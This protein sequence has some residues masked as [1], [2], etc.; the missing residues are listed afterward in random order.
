MSC[1][2]R[3]DADQTVAVLDRLTAERGTVAE[4]RSSV[5]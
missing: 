4:P 3:I 5:R 1:E 2:R